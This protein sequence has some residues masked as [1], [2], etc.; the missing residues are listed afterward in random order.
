MIF[1]G[2]CFDYSELINL[3]IMKK[4]KENN[5]RV[6]FN[7]EKGIKNDDLIN[8]WVIEFCNAHFSKD[9]TNILLEHLLDPNY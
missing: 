3:I 2:T 6:V 8:E 1:F 4:E 5:Q 7:L 9:Y